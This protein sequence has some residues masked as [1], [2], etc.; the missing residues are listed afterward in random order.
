MK[1]I[2]CYT[3]IN[4][5]LNVGPENIIVTHTILLISIACT[6]T[7]ISI[8]AITYL[9]RTIFNDNNND[10]SICLRNNKINDSYINNYIH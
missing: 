7:S 6:S 1:K 5:V 3:T 2:L 4:I 10:N 8:T 9:N